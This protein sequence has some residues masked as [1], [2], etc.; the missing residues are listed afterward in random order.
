M[1]EL[2]NRD[3][4]IVK[5]RALLAPFI[6]KGPEGAGCRRHSVAQSATQ[7]FMLAPSAQAKVAAAGNVVSL[8][9]VG[10]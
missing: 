8:A 2:G 9:V 3:L 6:S 4:Q 10:R 1:A 5:F 7:A